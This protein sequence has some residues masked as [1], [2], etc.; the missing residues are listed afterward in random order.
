M[1]SVGKTPRE[2]ESARPVTFSNP[3]KVYF[4]SGFTKGEMIR[5]YLEAAPF[6]LPHLQDRPVTLIRFP[7][8]VKGGSFYEKNAPKHAPDWIST[9][10][11]PR[12]HHEGRINYILINNPETLAWC[13]NLGAIE[14]HPFLHRVPDIDCPTHAAFDLDPGEGADIFTCIDVALR[15]K[16]VFDGL[17]LKSFPKVSGSKGLQVYVP[18]NTEV[19][20]ASTQPFAKSVAELLEREHPKLIVSKMSKALRKKKV[21]IDWSQNSRSKTTVCVYAMRGKRDEPF[22]S[23]PLSWSELTKAR[24]KENQA[25]LMF[26]PEEALRRM[27]KAGDLFAPVLTTRQHLPE[28]FQQLDHTADR[29]GGR[30]SPPRQVDKEADGTS[31]SKALA[32]YSAKRDFTRTAEPKGKTGKASGPD[33]E[34]RFVIQKHAASRLHYDFRLEIDATLKS[35]AVPK[36]PPYELGVKRAAFEVEDHPLEYREFEGTI[37]Q[38]QYGGGTVMVWDLGTYELL[39]GNLEKGDLK[40]RL[41]GKKLQ[42]EWHLFR[43]KSDP[44]KPVWLLAKSGTAAKPVSAR[45]DD[46]SVLTG[47]SMARIARDN[48]AQW[49]SNRDE[50]GA[51]APVGVRKR[52][53]AAAT[54]KPSARRTAKRPAKKQ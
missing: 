40:L 7:D 51:S 20:Y 32:R 18:L 11:V 49:K 22:I 5:Y 54:R 6:I 4:P 47:R 21:L 48:D 41:H 46:S 26:T 12:R 14:L 17:E 23:M 30:R 27:K 19:T 50:A 2:T 16:D 44:S 53:R 10:H 9:F 35:W 39:G 3:D 37:P 29:T 8:G 42:G 45:R 28:A 52:T 43:I 36:G 38:G 24:A 1:A 25:A 13:A 15:L 31:R 34:P 33:G